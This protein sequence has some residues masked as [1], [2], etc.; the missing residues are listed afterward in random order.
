MLDGIR[1]FHPHPSYS[2]G[3]SAQVFT[4][5][6]V[7]AGRL[8]QGPTVVFDDDHYY[9]ASVIAERLRLAGVAVTLVTT[10]NTVSAWGRFTYEQRRAQQRLM[11]LKVELIAAHALAS[12]DGGEAVIACQYTGRERRLAAESVVMVTARAPN[13]GLFHALQQR[14]QDGAE[15]APKSIAR[16]GDCEAPAIIASAVFSGHRY[17]RELDTTVDRDNPL[18]H[19]RVFSEEL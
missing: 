13:D 8:P 7:M 9:M 12:F 11:E 5:D 15:G 10:E 18:R 2:L 17:A 16:I 14:L 1:R 6:D 3:P 4:P 19:D